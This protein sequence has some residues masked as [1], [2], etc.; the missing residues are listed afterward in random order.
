MK[1]DH[2]R[3]CR[4]CGNDCEVCGKPH[5][6]ELAFRAGFRAGFAVSREG[7]NAE[8][9]YDNCAPDG[10][11][12]QDRPTRRQHGNPPSS[13]RQYLEDSAVEAARKD[14]GR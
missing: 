1:D 4:G 12:P 14:L 6:L 10:V 3:V 13:L 7:F 5:D 8:C 2:A 9:E 11:A